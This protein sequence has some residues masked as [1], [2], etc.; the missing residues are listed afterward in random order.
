[1]LI[2][3][4]REGQK[5]RRLAAG[6]VLSLA[7]IFQQRSSLLVLRKRPLWFSR[8]EPSVQSQILCSRVIAC[9]SF[10]IKM[11]SNFLMIPTIPQFC[12]AAS[13]LWA[14]HFFFL[15]CCSL[16]T[17]NHMHFNWKAEFKQ[18]PERCI[19]WWEYLYSLATKISPWPLANWR[20]SHKDNIKAVR[21]KQELWSRSKIAVLIIIQPLLWIQSFLSADTFS[22]LVGSLRALLS[23]R[24]EESASRRLNP[25]WCR[26]EERSSLPPAPW[27]VLCSWHPQR[28]CVTCTTGLV[29]S[30]FSHTAF[31]FRLTQASGLSFLFLEK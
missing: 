19:H 27:G 15:E 21:H 26:G 23:P 31:I 20:R 3:L 11:E 16:F 28:H 13:L 10:Y 24:K 8:H 17:H 2:R 7:S 4:Y 1:M 30:R 5:R 29:T 14:H 12:N 22:P 25:L 18:N 6:R 9:Y